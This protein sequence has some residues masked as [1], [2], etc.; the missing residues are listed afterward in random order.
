MARK[1]WFCSHVASI[2]VTERQWWLCVFSTRAAAAAGPT[3]M[4]T[5]GNTESSFS[6]WQGKQPQT[7][8]KMQWSQCF[9]QGCFFSH[10]HHCSTL[11]TVRSFIHPFIHSFILYTVLESIYFNSSIFVWWWPESEVVNQVASPDLTASCH[12][13]VSLGAGTAGLLGFLFLQWA[14]KHPALNFLT[15]SFIVCLWPCRIG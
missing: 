12:F 10:C 3:L 13:N 6:F 7:H 8:F 5:G 15:Y 1:K 9:N 11:C 14:I 4:T 2:W